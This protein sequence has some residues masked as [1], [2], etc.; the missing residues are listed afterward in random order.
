MK[1]VLQ[2]TLSVGLLA[3]CFATSPVRWCTRSPAEQAKCAK[4]Q[5]CFG[6]QPSANL[7]P[8]SCVMK[9]T[10]LDCIKAIANSEADATTLD[11]GHIF[12]AGLNP[13]NLKPIMAEVY[14][15]DQGDHTSYYAVAVVKKGTVSSLADLKGKKFCSTGIGRSAGW[16]I[17]VGT[18]LAKGYLE[19]A[20]AE[21]EPVEKAVARFTPAACVPGVKDEPNLCRLCAGKCTQNDPYSGYS[22]AFECLKSGGGDVAFVKDATVLAL[23]PADKDQYELLCYD[24]TKRPIGE[25]QNCFL[26]RVPAHAV[27]ARSVDGRADEIWA[28]L[29]NAQ[30]QFRTHQRAECQLLGTTDI[31]GKDLLFKDSAV[32]LVQVPS[33]LDSKLYLRIE[34]YAAVQNLRRERNL[35]PAANKVVWCAV[36]KAEQT[37]C[38]LWS[39]LSRGAI[40]CAVADT[41]EDCIVKI[42]KGE[43]DAISLDGGHIYTAGKCGLVPVLAEVYGDTTGVCNHPE[44][45][46]TVKGY[47][48]VAVVKKANAGITWNNLKGKKSCHTGVDRTAGW[49]IPMGLLYKKNNST[50]DFG[51]FFS[52]GC[53]PGS[54][55]DSPLCKLCKGSGGE[56]SI[57]DRYKCKPNSHE[58]YYGYNGAFR[59]LIEVGDVAFVKDSIVTD[60]TEGANK[61]AWVGSYQTSDF[62]LLHPNGERCP[63]SEFQRCGLATVPTHGVV[64]R[65]E[66]AVI[67]RNVVLEQQRSFGN[68]GSRNDEMQ[69]FQSQSK[70][71]LF[72]DGT[73]CLAVPKEN[74]YKTYLGQEYLDSV[75]G[76]KKCSPSE[77]LK[78]C[79]FT[80]DDSNVLQ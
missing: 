20:G 48:A 44:T 13:Y 12:D 35:P 37:K 25:Y 47:T 26:G 50:C 23:S 32:R 34:Y 11:G 39:G 19:W 18:L 61:P 71:C 56:G 7:P 14:H 10:H 66:K 51:K 58:I 74:T 53:A 21:T 68:T 24:G 73:Q 43:A 75:D 46:T 55:A 79:T 9:S 62:E 57:S 6:S 4:L 3:L 41:T 65:P 17:P 31:T 59:C 49:N 70:D 80:H 33:L 72:K 8:F 40:D 36:G 22:G 30:E 16:V 52:E 29:S 1:L 54:P 69:M 42:V 60:N 67:V 15:T 2:A 64:T 76:L 5:E 28:L 27:V 45:P 63:V 77:L 38:D 78:A